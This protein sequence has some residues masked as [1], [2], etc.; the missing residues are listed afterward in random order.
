[1]DIDAYIDAA[2]G[3]VGLTIPADCRPG[4]RSFLA[5]AA[6][7]AATLETMEL[8]DDDFALAPVLRLPDV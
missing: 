3:M 2:A 5:L 4:A 6:E 8:P 1:L 7:M